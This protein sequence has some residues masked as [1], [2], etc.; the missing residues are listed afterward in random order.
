MANGILQN[1]LNRLPSIN[2]QT[3]P[4]QNLG[5]DFSAGTPQL[6]EQS[7]PQIPT[8]GRDI[9]PS[10][11]G[12]IDQGRYIPIQLGPT[13]TGIDY[14]SRYRQRLADQADSGDGSM[15]IGVSAFYSSPQ[16]AQA[17]IS[18]AAANNYYGTVQD[19]AAQ[20]REGNQN[21]INAL[22]DFLGSGQAGTT[23]SA[24]L[25]GILGTIQDAIGPQGDMTV[26]QNITDAVSALDDAGALHSDDSSSGYVGDTL[27]QQQNISDAAATSTYGDWSSWAD[28]SSDDGD[29]WGGD[30]GLD[31][32]SDSFDSFGGGWT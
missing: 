7:I 3:Q 13:P 12:L 14:S 18:N 1:A 22:Q 23:Q 17:W 28:S 11:P 24:Q 15:D 6:V 32:S 16:E 29:S 26:P 27:T 4:S 21:A 20:A 8:Y 2:Q 19:A 25:P 5:W 10:G 9:A 30:S 31:S